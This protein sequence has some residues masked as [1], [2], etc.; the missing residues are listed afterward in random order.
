MADTGNLTGGCYCG[1]LRYEVT[2]PFVRRGECYC[3]ACQQVSGGGPNLFVLVPPSGFRFTSGHPRTYKKPNLPDAVTRLFCEACGTHIVTERPGLEFVVL[4][5]GTFDDP[6]HF[7]RADFA[8]FISQAQ[9]FHR[10]ADDI[11]A[12]DALP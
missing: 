9:V 4:K 2:E 12:F 5:V 10:L 7:K 11:P 1:A 3:R 8:I 6:G